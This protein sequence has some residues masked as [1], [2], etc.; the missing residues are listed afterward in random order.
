MPTLRERIARARDTLAAAGIP[1]EEAAFDAE[2]LA[3]HALG[4]DR[5]RIVVEGRDRVPP[6][7]TSAMTRSSHDAQHASPSRTSQDIASSGGSTS[8]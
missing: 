4:W 1:A 8:R 6:D 5:A 3:R 2:L 7:S